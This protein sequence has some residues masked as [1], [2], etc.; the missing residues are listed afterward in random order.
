MIKTI[1]GY[2]IVAGVTPEEY[3]RWLFDVHVPDI[4]ANPYVDRLVFNKVLRP[5]ERT[6]DGAPLP[7]APDPGLYRIAEMHFAD[8]Q[9]YRNYLDWF[10]AH[11][12]PAERGPGGRSDFRFYVIAESV[13][14]SR[15]GAAGGAGPVADRGGPG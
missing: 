14:F 2:A 8:E 3:E 10:A 4:M 11:P 9:A 5:V 6:S 15:D 1:L 13:A 12:V 7:V